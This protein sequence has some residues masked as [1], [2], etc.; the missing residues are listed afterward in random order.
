RSRHERNNIGLGLPLSAHQSR[1]QSSMVVVGADGDPSSDLSKSEPVPEPIIEGVESFSEP[2]RG[3]GV[4]IPSEPVK[5][6]GGKHGCPHEESATL[7]VGRKSACAHLAL[8]SLCAV[9]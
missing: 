5:G 1:P 7:V 9:G 3:E 2:V 6:E 4:K 8:E